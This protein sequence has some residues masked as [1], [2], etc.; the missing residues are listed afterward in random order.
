MLEITTLPGVS[1]VPRRSRALR[2]IARANTAGG[3][4]S[5]KSVSRSAGSAWKISLLLDME[6]CTRRTRWT[7]SG[8]SVGRTA[9][10]IDSRF[11]QRSVSSAFRIETGISATSG[12]SGSAPRGVRQVAK[13]AGTDVHDHVFNR[14]VEP[15]L[16]RLDVVQRR[17]PDRQLAVGRDRRVE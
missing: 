2:R 10:S 9:D 8:S 12:S 15:R 16:D 7:G 6:W 4:N 5:A 14:D 11:V 1:R 3:G 13:A 17:R